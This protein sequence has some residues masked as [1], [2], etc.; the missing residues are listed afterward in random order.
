VGLP[1][2]RREE[3]I[4]DLLLQQTLP[5]LA[6]G[7]VV[8][9]LGLDVEIEE[10]LEEQ[11]IAQPLTELP[12]AADR[13]EGHQ[14]RR[15]EQLLWGHAVPARGG[16]HGLELRLQIR[17]NRLHHRLDAPDG[18][19]G[20]DQ[21]VRGQTG[22]HRHLQVGGATHAPI[23]ARLNSLPPD[24]HTGVTVWGPDQRAKIN[25]LLGEIHQHWAGL[26]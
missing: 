16:I 11:V 24:S 19:V 18:V 3:A 8:K 7:A 17:Q 25:T 20:W 1:H 13:V 9:A 15:F 10:E 21:A 14:H 5:V 2:H 6:E 4:G 22:Q 26:G 23:S 12:L